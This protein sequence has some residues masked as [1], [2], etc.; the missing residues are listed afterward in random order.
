MQ[1]A[2]D[3]AIDPVLVKREA[4]RAKVTLFKRI[5]YGLMLISIAA[6]FGCLALEWPQ[7]LTTTAIVTFTASCIVLPLP[8]IFGYAIKAAEKEDRKMG[9]S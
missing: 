3:P 2:L 4:I 5:G 1:K 6:F 7:W 8:I 9:L